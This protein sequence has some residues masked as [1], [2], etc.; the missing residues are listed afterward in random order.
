MVK[1]KKSEII[2]NVLIV[3][4]S[5]LILYKIIGIY[6]AYK[7]KMENPYNAKILPWSIIINNTDIVVER[8]FD[9]NDIYTLNENTEEGKIAPGTTVQ[10]PIIINA[11][12]IEKMNVKYE[13]EIEINNNDIGEFVIQKVEE[14]NNQNIIESQNNIYTGVITEEEINNGIIHDIRID[15]QWINNEKNNEQDTIKA[16]EEERK[17]VDINI[18]VKAMQYI[19]NNSEDEEEKDE[20]EKDEEEKDIQEE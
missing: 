19:M 8:R 17:N 12:N 7:T 13:I 2:K 11:L 20:E 4:L 3:I 9:I 15:I 10:I 18:K 16:M 14:L 1:Q 6:A 5:I